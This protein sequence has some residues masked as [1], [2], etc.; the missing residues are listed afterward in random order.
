MK[1]LFVCAGNTC[2]SPLAEVIARRFAIDRGMLSL[3][4]ESAGTEAYAGAPASDGSLLVALERHLDLSQHRARPLTRSLVDDADLILGMTP[5]HVRR[6]IALGGEGKSWLLSDFAH[7]GLLEVAVA[8][9]YGGSLDDYRRT[10]D[11]LAA[12]I[13][14]VLDRLARER[15]ETNL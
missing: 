11:E 9:P 6:A 12:H 14:L 2:R 8:D 3:D 15:A 4:I 13:R 7:E 5:H 10:A 1:L